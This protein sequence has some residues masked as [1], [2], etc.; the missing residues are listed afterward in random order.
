[1]RLRII[2]LALVLALYLGMTAFAEECFTFRNGVHLGMTYDE[3]VAA[4]GSEPDYVYENTLWYGPVDL[5]GLDYDTYLVYYLDAAE[6]LGIALYYND[7]NGT[8]V[9]DYMKATLSSVYGE[10]EPG[11]VQELRSAVNDYWDGV[12]E[13]IFDYYTTNVLRWDMGDTYV[14]YVN[15]S[16]SSDG[17]GGGLAVIYVDPAKCVYN[18]SGL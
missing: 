3:I 7:E 13:D 8:E 2:S 18:T 4:E 14:Y 11:T 17:R 9:A 5:C 12:M 16:Y 6:K 1:M 15:Y 10:C